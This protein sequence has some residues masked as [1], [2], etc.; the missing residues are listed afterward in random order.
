[1]PS[2]DKRN[3]ELSRDGK[4]EFGAERTL[5]EMTEERPEWGVNS[6]FAA[7]VESR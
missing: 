7:E 4:R 2:L 6:P 5:L 3:P 1:M